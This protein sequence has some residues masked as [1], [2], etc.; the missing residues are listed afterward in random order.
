MAPTRRQAS[1]SQRPANGRSQ[2]DGPARSQ[3]TRRARVESDDEVDEN[4]MDVDAEHS[5]AENAEGEGG[6]AVSHYSKDILL[7]VFTLSRI[8]D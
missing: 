6:A 2:R 4:E 5:E 8:S 1:Q 7:A 3:A